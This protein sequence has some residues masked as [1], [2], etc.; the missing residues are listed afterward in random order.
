M[1]TEISVAAAVQQ[2]FES[3]LVAIRDVDPKQKYIIFKETEKGTMDDD[4]HRL[5][6]RVA[7]KLGWSEKGGLETVEQ[8]LIKSI[9]KTRRPAIGGHGSRGAQDL[10]P[11]VRLLLPD[12]EE[13]DDGGSG[14]ENQVS[15]GNSY[16]TKV[17]M[18]SSDDDFDQFLVEQAT[19]KAASRKH[20]TAAK[21][22]SEPVLVLSSESDDSFE[23]FLSRVKTPKPKPKE[24]ERGSEDSLRNFIVDSFSSD[25]DFVVEKKKPST[26]KGAFNT[27]KL[28]SSQPPVRRP[29]SQCD[30]PVFLSDSEEEDGIVMKST[31][32][33][34]NPVHQPPPSQKLK[35]LQSNQKSCKVAN[36]FFP[37]PA[38][39]PLPSPSPSSPP[40]PLSSFTPSPAS[41]PQRTHSAPSKL[42]DSASSEEEF[43][44]LLDRIKKNHKTGNTPTPKRNTV[45]NQKPPLSA[46][47]PKAS[48]EAGPRPVGRTPLDLKTPVRPLVTKPTVS[49]TES[50]LQTS[51]LSSSRVSAV[52]MTP[53]CFLQSLSGP[54][55]SYSRN[56]KQTKEELTSKLYCLYNTSVFDSKLPSNM[57]VSWN[58]KMRK[59]AGYCIT[60]QERGGG[61]RYARIQL[62]EKVCDS[63][64]RLRDTLVHEMCHAATWLINSVRDG[65]GPFWKLYARKATLA[66]PELPTVTRCHSYDINY[67]YQYQCSRC[68]NTLGRHSKSLDTQRFVCALCTG[69][70]VLL[71]PA[72]PRAPTPFANF[73]KEN[74]GSVR[75]DLVGQSHGD[76]MRKLSVDFATKTKL[77]QS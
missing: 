13:E 45:P 14:K 58:K 59:T 31:W 43:L 25:D 8:Q 52:C 63:A 12:S 29:L 76:V 35:V 37:S 68:K 42:E 17:F 6:Q 66:H 23:N 5:F 55:S 32:R 47:R 64:D 15:K 24:A 73:V 54:G 21:K 39:P 4:N 49:Q 40:P 11:P 50:R 48:K 34:R 51:S 7:E 72:K 36:I 10:P 70:L 46:P 44:S 77:S 28:S 65:H 38:P 16:R 3:S 30:S 67:K 20:C 33:T 74:Y 1:A 69:Q 62:S 53:G 57:S 2:L 56:F 22:V 26:S 19:P 27:P 41:V 18:E 61:N 60:G 75:Q 71:T 9:S